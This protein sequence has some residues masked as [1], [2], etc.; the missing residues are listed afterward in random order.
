MVTAAILPMGQAPPPC[1]TQVA[2]AKTA[3]RTMSGTRTRTLKRCPRAI[4]AKRLMI[5]EHLE[6]LVGLTFHPNPLIF[7]PFVQRSIPSDGDPPRFRA[8]PHL[9]AKR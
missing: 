7:S 9:H 6:D 8:K 4:P 2:T 5:A 3:V 1:A